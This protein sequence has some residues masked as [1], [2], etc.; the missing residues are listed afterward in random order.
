MQRE[1]LRP[2]RLEAQRNR[3]QIAVRDV[4]RQRSALEDRRREL[5]EASQQEQGRWSLHSEQAMSSRC[6]FQH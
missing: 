6:I 3:A 5:A 2:T 4:D 1:T